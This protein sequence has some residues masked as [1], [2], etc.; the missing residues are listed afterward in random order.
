MSD[1][2]ATAA[3]L[4]LGTLVQLGQNDATPLASPP[5]AE[6][7]LNVGEVTDV[8][9]SGAKADTVD[10]TNHQSIEGYREFLS[11]LREAGEIQVSGNWIDPAGTP[12]TDF[13]TQ[14]D[15]EALFDSGERRNWHIVVPPLAGEMSSPGYFTCKAIVNSFGDSNFSPEKLINYSFKLK[16]SGKFTYVATP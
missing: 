9:K 12:P 7:F 1:Y 11:G 13:T 4:G 6:T 3:R 8:A 16:I 15:V 14:Q 10:A 2:V 5:G